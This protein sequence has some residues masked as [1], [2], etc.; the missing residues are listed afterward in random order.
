MPSGLLR[1][2][3]REIAA[4][5]PFPRIDN[6]QTGAALLALISRMQAPDLSSGADINQQV[7]GAASAAAGRKTWPSST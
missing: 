4:L 1:R 7:I 5:I 6:P 3:G 2:R